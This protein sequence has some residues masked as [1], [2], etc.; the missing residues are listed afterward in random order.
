MYDVIV[1]GA[2][3]AGLMC[4][5]NLKTDNY[6]VLEKTGSAGNKLLISGGGRCNF[7]N[8]KSEKLFIENLG[9]NEKYLHSTIN[10]F[11][12]KGIIEFFQSKIIL[13]EE[14]DN[15]IFPQSDKSKDVLNVLLEKVLPNI[16]FNCCVLEIIKEKGF[17]KIISND[18]MY[19][20]KYLVIAS[21]GASFPLTGSTGDHTMFAMQLNQKFVD[22]YPAETS[23][24][25]KESFS[26]SLEGLSFDNVLVKANKKSLNGN[27]MFTK[28][29]LS[30]SVIMNLSGYIYLN[31]VNFIDI[32]F[33]PDLSIDKILVNKEKQLVGAFSGI[34]PKRL[35]CFL[36]SNYDF[37]E[38]KIKSISKRDINFIINEL[39]NKRFFVKKVNDLNKAYV[40]GGGF[41]L[42]G[43]NTK[44]FESISDE[45]L[46]FAGE[47]LD[48]HGPIGGYNITLALSTGASVSRAINEK[49]S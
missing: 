8:N 19:I 26:S 22:L 36:F 27:L 15:K 4:A 12:P 25:L 24:I 2:G 43:V 34:L 1:I 28:N 41:D 17:Y 49:L 39:T 29:G 13:K 3:P 23:I 14:A 20:T 38:K 45:G 5:R 42:N 6:V 9:Y 21:G 46:F 18:N 10:Y 33:L 7:S 16:I 35:L 44:S 37:Y 40:T 32:N 11:G 48:V 47:C 31:N 30:G